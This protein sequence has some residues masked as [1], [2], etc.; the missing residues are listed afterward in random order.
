MP[1][2]F[3]PTFVHML[4][5]AWLAGAAGGFAGFLIG[6]VG[7]RLAMFILRLTSE[8]F[9]RGAESDDGFTIGKFSLQTGFLL[10]VTAALGSIAAVLYMGVR[11]A[12]PPR[13][14]RAMWAT[15]C[16]AI[17]GAAIV[18]RDGVDF[19]VL[20]PTSLAIAMFIAIPAGGAWLMAYFIDRWQPWWAENRRRT[21]LAS[22]AV[23]PIFLAGV[24]IVP[25]AVIVATA[26][27]AILAQV[28]ALHSL[29]TH[30]ALR[31]AVCLGLAALTGFALVDLTGDVRTLL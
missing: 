18:H 16:G 13:W 9:V 27:V 1:S 3:R 20:E 22:L 7:G 26:V 19:K 12:L 8:D 30:I 10:I 29:A 4:R 2:G 23:V 21:A 15:A 24:G 5:R 14:R 25:G 28:G 6:G 17:G 11:P 31:G